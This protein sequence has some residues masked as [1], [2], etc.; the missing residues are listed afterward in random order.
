MAIRTDIARE[1]NELPLNSRM[2]GMQRIH[3]WIEP[4]KIVLDAELRDHRHALEAAA[5]EIGIMQGLAPEPVLRA[6]WRRE[7]VGST[8]IGCG[9]A[10]PHARIGG[11]K[12]PIT[13]FMRSKWAIDFAAPDGKPVR[14][15]LIIMVP[16]DGDIDEHLQLLAT[17]A[18]MFSDSAFREHIAA[19]TNPEEARE[20]F[21]NWSRAN[22][23]GASPI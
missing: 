17:I 21:A 3:A 18:Q 13:L 8:A 9:V 2:L 1:R 6:L 7:Q 14:N 15:I 20:E 12:R 11:I 16:T 4:Q 10:I 19:A 22:C 5:S 23:T